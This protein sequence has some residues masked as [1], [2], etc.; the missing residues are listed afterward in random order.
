MINKQV[1][2][3]PLPKSKSMSLFE[4]SLKIMFSSLDQVRPETLSKGTYSEQDA[5]EA[6]T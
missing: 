5:I 2:F 3:F 6:Y 4:R 1:I